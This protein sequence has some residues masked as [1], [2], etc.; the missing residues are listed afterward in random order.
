M[1]ANFLEKRDNLSDPFQGAELIKYKES[2]YD[3]HKK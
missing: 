1:H 2:M 3:I